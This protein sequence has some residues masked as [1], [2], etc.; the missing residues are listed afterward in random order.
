MCSIHPGGRTGKTHLH[1]DEKSWIKVTVARET[2]RGE[3]WMEGDKR[4]AEEGRGVDKRKRKKGNRWG[5]NGVADGRARECRL[6]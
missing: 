4:V 1:E 3:E 6:Q 2:R 5:R